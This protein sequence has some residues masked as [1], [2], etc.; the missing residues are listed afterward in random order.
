MSTA[1]EK[2]KRPDEC[3]PGPRFCLNTEG[4]EHHW[5][6][7]TITTEQIA[8]VGGWD[9]NQGVIQV[10]ADNNERTLEPGEVV[11]LKPGMGF[12]KKVRWKRGAAHG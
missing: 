11:A 12:C 6:V 2:T 7:S 1:T 10:D 9:V 4:V 3:K 5:P 8:E